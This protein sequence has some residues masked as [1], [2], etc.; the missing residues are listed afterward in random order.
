MAG[1]TTSD[2]LIQVTGLRKAFGTTLVLDGVDL[3]IRAG[4][5]VGLLGPNGAGKT[6]LLKILATVARPTRGAARIAGHDCA[7]EA[8]RVRGLV[9]LVAHGTHLYDDLTALENLKFWRRFAGERPDPE[10]L[11]G[12]L[13]QVEL[14]DCADVRVRTFSAGMKRR[15]SLA[16]MLLARPRVL[17]LDEP[18]SSLDQGA[19]KW[20]EQ[21]LHAFTAGGGAIL[22]ATHAFGRELDVAE[23]LVILAN[24]RIIADT[25][26]GTLGAEEIHRLYALHTE[27]AS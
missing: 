25:P 23:R 21:Y 1:L 6:T 19:R 20:L 2:A 24:G 17:L 4:E 12:A 18:F 13:A 7:R 14:D 10:A 15:L 5:A 8:E 11:Q 9:G 16:R 22:M 27:D 26:R 3:S